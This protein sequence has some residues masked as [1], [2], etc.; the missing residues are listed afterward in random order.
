MGEA[1]PSDAGHRHL[2]EGWSLGAAETAVLARLAAW[3]TADA[4]GAI[5][6][7]DPAF[8]PAADPK[9]VP[10]RLGW[11]ALPESMG[12]RL[13]DIHSFAAEVRGGA[14]ERILLLGMGGS[15][16]ASSV[17]ARTWGK[18]PG[19]PEL[20]ILDS[21]HPQAVR[22]AAREESARRTLF[23]VSSK[24]GT[25]LEPNS[26]FEYFW[27]RLSGHGASPGGNFV[28]ITDPGTPLE[29]LAKSHGFRRLFSSPPD[30]GGRYSALTEFG[31]IPA[32]LAGL[33]V[34]RV[35]Q[36]AREMAEES[37]P[38]VVASHSPGLQLGAA[39]GELA[40]LGRNKVTFVTSPALAAFPA[41]A[42]QLIA[43]STGKRDTG[44]VP[45][46]GEVAPFETTN[47][48]DRVLV[49]LLL[50]GEDDTDLEAGLSK[51]EKAGIPVLRFTLDELDDLGAEFFRW[52]L[53]VAAAGAILGI[54]P[55]DQPDVERA[56]EFA[57]RA[58]ARDPRGGGPEVPLQRADQPAELGTAVT[59]WVNL[60]NVG[61]YLAI[62][63]F[64]APSEALDIHLLELR[65]ALRRKLRLSS[66]L[67]YGPRF[68]H[69][70]GQLHK[71]G[72]PS[73]LFLQ[74]VDDPRNAEELPDGR[75]SFAGIIRAQAAGDAEAL[76]EKNRRLLR[77]D[78]G[79]DA[80][81]GLKILSAAVGA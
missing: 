7:K 54:D 20:E 16:L 80:V 65:S 48:G 59:A 76:R 9:E 38:A 6:R 17:F 10:D 66:T 64:L 74:L 12:G 63:A 78:L 5:W 39:L 71:G 47:S 61:D 46:A 15:S 70:T 58:M 34:R 4:S 30:V 60:A 72:P 11:L 22:H 8:W 79:H 19:F 36:R 33:D 53:A 68:L 67:G 69:S 28:A 18:V 27:A 1:T 37:S 13:D 77:V 32:A 24:S 73:G 14:F 44:I 31:L 40:R 43:E 75:G 81:A 26:F 55:F 25:T 29:Q 49:K 57:R 21:T 52:E 56:K 50:R 45:V 3:D 51:A 42:E 41:W 23:L 62:Q 35:V 2:P